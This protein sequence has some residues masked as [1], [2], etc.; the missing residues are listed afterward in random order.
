MAKFVTRE[1]SGREEDREGA[2]KRYRLYQ[3]RVGREWKVTACVWLGELH[4][5][6]VAGVSDRVYNRYSAG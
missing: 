4:S 2:A 6:T 5:E 3:L 1:M